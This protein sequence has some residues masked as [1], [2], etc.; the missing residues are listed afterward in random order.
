MVFPAPDGPTIATL[1]PAGIFKVK[2]SR[3]L[4]F[5]NF[6]TT[7]LQ[8]TSPFITIS[9]PLPTLSLGPFQLVP[10]ASN[11]DLKLPNS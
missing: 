7:S 6:T 2:P 9:L 11:V 8:T 4:V 3:A 10:T 1:V 5:S